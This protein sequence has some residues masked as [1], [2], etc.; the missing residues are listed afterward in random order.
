[1]IALSSPMWNEAFADDRRRNWAPIRERRTIFRVITSFRGERR[2]AGD[3]G[4]RAWPIPVPVRY[5]RPAM[6][7]QEEPLE[8]LRNGL[9][10]KGGFEAG[11][12]VRQ[13]YW[14]PGTIVWVKADRTYIQF[15]LSGLKEFDTSKAHF[16]LTK[17]APRQNRISLSSRVK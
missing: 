7:P 2:H 8:P 3:Y 13:R 16:L 5:D 15:D 6:P 10:L 4:H 1:M 17:E 14:G 12:H 9:T 11:D